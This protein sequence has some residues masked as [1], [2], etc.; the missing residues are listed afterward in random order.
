MKVFW[1]MCIM[2][3]NDT[4]KLPWKLEADNLPDHYQLSI[5]QANYLLRHL[6]E[7]KELLAKYDCIIQEQLE[8][9]VIEIVD[10]KEMSD[11]KTH[12]M[13]DHGV[14]RENK[15]TTKLR[16]V[17]D[18]SAHEKEDHTSINSCLRQGPN[19]IPS[20]VDILL[21]FRI[22]QVGLVA[23]IEKAFLM[24]GIS[25]VEEIVLDPCGSKM[26]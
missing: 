11:R 3:G 15:S 2:T 23:D 9:G 25:P 24:I 26:L 6:Q 16:I 7:N 13:P 17:Y 18:G 5:S 10:P 8:A 20:L 1:M 4:M 22:H 21:R 19:L 14:I 12:Y